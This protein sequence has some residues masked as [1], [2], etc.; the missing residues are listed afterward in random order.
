MEKIRSIGYH[1]LMNPSSCPILVLVAGNNDPSNSNMLADHFIEGMKAVPGVTFE[2]IRVNELS[3]EHFRLDLYEN[4]D[5]GEPDY[6][7]LK[8]LVEDAKG[9]VIATPI[10]NFSVPAHLKNLID[11]IG[12]FTLDHET[13]SK[14][15]LKGKP[16][17]LIYTGG[18]PLIAW[19]AL[20]Y[21]TTLHVAEAFKYY[22]GVIVSRHFEARCVPG[23]GQF[24]LV[25]DK[26]PA[27]LEKMKRDGKKFAETAMC[28]ATTGALPLRNR[29]WQKWFEFLYRVGNRIMYPISKF[30]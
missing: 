20:M 23:K 12:A 4:P 5:H 30:Q 24:G 3:L 11:R 18:A 1:L 21:L 22:N 6:L 29:I 16:I 14:G 9:I 10:W 7:R 19:Q 28:Y 27:T 8:T 17:G 2:K 13:H 15:Q 25:V 26:R